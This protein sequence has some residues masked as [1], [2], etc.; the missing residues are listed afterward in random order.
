M[1]DIDPDQLLKEL[2]TKLALMR[3]RRR[4]P[5]EAS[6]QSVRIGLLAVFGVLLVMVL[7]I[8]QAYLSQMTPRRPGGP[9]PDGPAPTAAR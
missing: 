2:D 5:R 3:A 7:W 4:A 9:T 8:L 1:P 6:N